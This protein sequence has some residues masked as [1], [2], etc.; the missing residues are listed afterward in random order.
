[1]A[2]L[3]ARL[4]VAAIECASGIPRLRHSRRW[5]LTNPTLLPTSISAVGRR[6]PTG[7]SF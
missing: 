6:R 7:T 1:M 3:L 2:N 4:N 5:A